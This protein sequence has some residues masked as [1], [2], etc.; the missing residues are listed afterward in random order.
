MSRNILKIYLFLATLLFLIG[1]T[2]NLEV[3]WTDKR[4][5]FSS[6]ILDS[7][8]VAIFNISASATNSYISADNYGTNPLIANRD[9]ANLWEN[10]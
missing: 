4:Q 2:A 7:Q 5:L 10:F 9:I 6:T 3:V 1:N 8:I